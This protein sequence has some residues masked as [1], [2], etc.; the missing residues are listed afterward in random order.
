MFAVF[1]H[2]LRRQQN[3]ILG[4]G[5][6]FA[7]L[8]WITAAAYN[9]LYESTQN[10]QGMLDS[11]P[12]GWAAFFGGSGLL[13]S[14]TSY[15]D[16]S[17]FSYGL[18]ILGFFSVLA[19]AGM[20]AG[21]EEAGRLDLV[22]S[23]PVSRTAQFAGRALAMMAATVLI[24]VLFWAGFLPG[25]PGSKLEITLATLA[26]PFLPLLAEMLLF[27]GFALWLSMV[28]PSR[29]M[30][31]MVAGILLIG[32]YF[33][34]SL[35]RIVT[36]LEPVARFSPYN[37][38]QGAQAIDGLNLPWFFGLLGAAALLFLAAGWCYRR[39]DLRVSGEGGWR[40]PGWLLLRK[41]TK[42]PGE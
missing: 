8:G 36:T 5:L 29:G 31:T 30:A 15:L 10:W 26:L 3:P 11:L 6:T 41:K 12:Q 4:W 17:I 32:G 13:F 20:L 7:F 28:L 27:S 1:L 16:I 23:Y 2:E 14:T 18:A 25:L 19:G 34:S 42:Q 40:M 22:Q 35:A 38:Y 37:Y 39:R 24:L 21:D 9:P 33:L